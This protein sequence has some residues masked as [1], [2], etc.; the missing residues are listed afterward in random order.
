WEDPLFSSE[1]A[2]RLDKTQKSYGEWEPGPLH[3]K[4]PATTREFIH[5]AV[6]TYGDR[7]VYNR[8]QVKAIDI[9]GTYI[10]G[11]YQMIAVPQ[12][13]NDIGVV[14]KLEYREEKL[15]DEQ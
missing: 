4:P 14:V 12:A 11:T 10:H 6:F 1:L 15:K 13:R 9:N 7:G 3:L 5:R 2:K 8:N